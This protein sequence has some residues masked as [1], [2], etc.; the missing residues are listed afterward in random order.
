MFKNKVKNFFIFLVMTLSLVLLFCG[1]STSSNGTE[2][3]QEEKISS[4]GDD[5]LPQEEVLP[6]FLTITSYDIGTVTYAQIAGISEGILKHSNIKI[7]QRV[8]GTESGRIIPV[9]TGDAHF[10]AGTSNTVHFGNEGTGDFATI[11]W[12]PQGLQQVWVAD[13]TNVT[14]VTA[15]DSGIKT[16]YD[17]EGRKYP[18]VEAALSAT[19]VHEA[20]LRFAG[21]TWD[22]VEKVEL[23]GAGAIYNSILEGRTDAVG[24][25][26]S[27]SPFFELAG[28]RR[29]I[30]VLE[31]PKDDEEAW[32]RVQAFAPHFFPKVAT[33]GAGISEGETKEVVGYAA[34]V[35]LTYPQLDE[36]IA[37][38]FTKAMHESFDDYKDVHPDLPCFAIEDAITLENMVAPYHEGSVKYFR[39]IG[40]WNDEFEAKQNQL[41]ARQDKLKGLWEET[42]DEAEEN[43]ISAGEF[44]EFWMQKREA[45]LN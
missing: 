19:F 34:P 24:G 28:T 10:V 13:T 26:L 30:H 12:G 20:L 37:Y 3:P 40:W 32:A 31:F 41:L 7:R 27:A 8:S 11:D 38:S 23:P 43:D 45:G 2:P 17:L 22:D 5:E 33:E 29:G 42:L 16:P 39:E 15:A 9:R 1:C 25:G 21:L 4:P 44:P 35:F 18:Y 6:D 36:F 14:L